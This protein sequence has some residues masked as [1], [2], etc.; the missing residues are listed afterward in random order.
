MAAVSSSSPPMGSFTVYN[1]ADLNHLDLNSPNEV[2]KRIDRVSKE[3]L[4]G[5]FL[6]MCQRDLAACVE[7][8]IITNKYKPFAILLSCNDAP[9]EVLEYNI[10]IEK[11][12]N[13]LRHLYLR[14]RKYLIMLI[15]SQFPIDLVEKAIREW[16]ENIDHKDRDLSSMK[17]WL[18]NQKRYFNFSEIFGGGS[19]ITDHCERACNEIKKITNRLKLK[20]TD[21][22]KEI[23]KIVTTINFDITDIPSEPSREIS[24]LREGN[25]NDLKLNQITHLEEQ[26]SIAVRQIQIGEMPIKR[27]IKET[28]DIIRENPTFLNGK[29]NKL[30]D[31]IERLK[32]L[33]LNRK[34]IVDYIL[35]GVVW[36]INCIATT[37]NRHNIPSKDELP[38]LPIPPTTDQIEKFK[39]QV[40]KTVKSLYNHWLET[41]E[42]SYFLFQKAR[43]KSTF[44]A[45]ENEKRLEAFCEELEKLVEIK[46]EDGE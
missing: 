38:Y 19:L 26:L 29:V 32:V 14:Q 27:F 5:I 45:E 37:A 22:G 10:I 23:T 34:I 4:R 2:Y 1:D 43:K 24:Y 40:P 31:D 46:E 36:R 35:Q 25:D 44:N 39:E 41:A 9:D 20:Q 30:F 42:Y 16:F 12:K 33:L 21:N 3:I 11:I 28:R 17:E 7:K 8:A 15:L 13:S 18:D 6:E